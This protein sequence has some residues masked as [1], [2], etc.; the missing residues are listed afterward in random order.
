MMLHMLSFSTLSPNSLLLTTLLTTSVLVPGFN[1]L[2]CQYNQPIFW[3]ISCQDALSSIITINVHP[4]LKPNSKPKPR[5]KI[6]M[7]DITSVIWSWRHTS[8]QIVNVILKERHQ[9]CFSR[10]WIPAGAESG[11]KND[12][13]KS[14]YL[15]LWM[16]WCTSTALFQNGWWKNIDSENKKTIKY[17]ITIACNCIKPRPHI[18]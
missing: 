16:I 2:N 8:G 12:E 7:A 17:C 10:D 1:L 9:W 4:K 14:G 3:I 11:K 18:T 15:T 6:K 5:S 13:Y